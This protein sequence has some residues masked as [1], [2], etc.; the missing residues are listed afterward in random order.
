MGYKFLSKIATRA[1]DV[2]PNTNRTQAATTLRPRCLCTPV[3]PD[4][5]G[6][7]P[8]AVAWRYLRRARYNAI[9]VGSNFVP[10]DSDF[11]PWL[12]RAR[13][14]TRLPCEFGANPFSGSRY[15][16][17]IH[18]QKSHRQR[19]KTEPYGKQLDLVTDAEYVANL[20]GLIVNNYVVV[21]VQH[22]GLLHVYAITYLHNDIFLSFIRRLKFS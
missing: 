11:W 19:Q 18:K 16:S 20:I 5:D 2:L 14:Q 22:C 13:D 4:S 1:K 21:N 7:V 3:T 6:M 12:V 9:S 17:Y 8:S 10:G 15:I